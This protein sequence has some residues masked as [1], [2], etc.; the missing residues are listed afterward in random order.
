[1]RLQAPLRLKKEDLL[2]YPIK[3][4]PCYKDYIWGGRNLEKLGKKLPEGIVAESWEIACHPDGTNIIA[5]GE[6][7]GLSF[8]ELLSKHKSEVIGSG[9]AENH[10]GNQYGCMFPLLIKLIDANDKLS[11]Q[12]HPDDEYARVHENGE[13]GKNEMWYILDAKPGAKIIYD[14]NPRTTRKSFEGAVKNGTIF[15]CLN[16]VEVSAGDVINIPA[17]I[18]HAIGEGIVIAE[19]QQNSNTT[20][21]V[22]DY[23][24]IGKDGSKRPLHIDKAIDVINFESGLKSAKI[25]GLK[26]DIGKNSYKTYYIA[27]KYFSVEMYNLNSEIEE[28]TENRFC[29]FVLIDGEATIESKGIEVKVIR[30]ESVLVPAAMGK[31]SIKGNFKALKAYI[32]DIQKDIIAPLKKAGY[33]E[34]EIYN[35]IGG[36]EA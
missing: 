3:F 34:Q 30:G 8:Q 33:S 17:G 11:V 5:N 35:N 6:Y 31:Y 16:V 24:R 19:I 22:Y 27:N 4:I 23:D 2:L 14:L 28:S 29:I 36:L 26:I 1:L 32:P 9:Y 15:E 10:I 18:I 13:L 25:K 20:Y 7:K 12:V 21:R